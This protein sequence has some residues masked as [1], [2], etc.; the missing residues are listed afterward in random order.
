MSGNGVALGW[1]WGGGC[2]IT[3]ATE[4]MGGQG[5]Y[6]RSQ[7]CAQLGSFTLG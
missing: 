7:G 2:L 4:V 5:D 3:A 1:G 6:E